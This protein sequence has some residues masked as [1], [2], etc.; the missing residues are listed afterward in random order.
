VSD[1]LVQARRADS[2]ARRE[3]VL[4][5][6][7]EVTGHT[8]VPLTV[9]EIARR[10][11]VH[12]SF[13]HRHDELTNALTAA[14]ARRTASLVGTLHAANVVTSASLAADLAN[15]RATSARLRQDLDVCRR[16]VAEQLGHAVAASIDATPGIDWQAVASELQ[17]EVEQLTTTNRRLTEEIEAVRT[18]NRDLTRMI[19]TPS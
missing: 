14:R 13:L 7:T 11:Q 15:E 19:N 9:V 3:R 6:I 8:E 12:R 10:A 16:R 2:A 4:A 1:Q 18:R 5:V 17:D